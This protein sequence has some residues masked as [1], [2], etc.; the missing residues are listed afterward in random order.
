M[1]AL[2]LC[3]A[4]LITGLIYG[5]TGQEINELLMEDNVRQ[6]TD[7]AKKWVKAEEQSAEACYWLGASLYRFYSSSELNPQKEVNSII[8]A[9]IAFEKAKYLDVSCAEQADNSKM[10]NAYASKTFNL[11]VLSYQKSDVE[12]AFTYFKMTSEAQDWMGKVDEDA[13]FYGG[14]CATEIGNTDMAKSYFQKVLNLNPQNTQAIKKLASTHI[15]LAE[16]EDAKA[17]L[18]TSLVNNPNDADL[19]YELMNVTSQLNQPEEA[20]EAAL[21]LSHLESGNAENLA[22]LGSL[23]DKLGEKEKAMNTY[24]NCL[25]LDDSHPMAN[26]NLGVLHYNDAVTLQ[27]VANTPE[28]KK[29][30]AKSLNEA[31]KFLVKAK[32]SGQT[33]GDVDMLLKNLD[34]MK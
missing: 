17:L 8:D 9:G 6:A 16:L 12:M 34:Q 22:F 18:K 28:K 32:E 14:L 19:W 31:E 30:L 11:G 1:K 27:G 24:S 15:K 29:E 26:Y 20:L 2:I 21:T 13:L 10:L 4:L 25:E 7:L 33:K 5:Q 23:Y 3:T